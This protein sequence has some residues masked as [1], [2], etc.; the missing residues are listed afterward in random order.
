MLTF[1]VCRLVGCFAVCLVACVAYLVGLLVCF[2]LAWLVLDGCRCWLDLFWVVILFDCCCF[3][4]FVVL[5]LFRFVVL[6][7]GGLI[8]SCVGLLTFVALVLG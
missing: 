2:E 1:V 3:D 4:C 6:L 8:C 5:F 7:F